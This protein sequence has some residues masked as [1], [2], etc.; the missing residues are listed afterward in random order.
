MPAISTLVLLGGA[1]ALAA[2]QMAQ[3]AGAKIPFF[4]VCIDYG[5]PDAGKE[6][7][8]IYGERLDS[9]LQREFMLIL[10][11]KTSV[12]VVPSKLLMSEGSTSVAG[13]SLPF[14]TVGQLAS[15]G[16]LAGKRVLVTT[17]FG[18]VVGDIVGNIATGKPAERIAMPTGSPIMFGLL[19]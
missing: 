17:E 1:A 14:V 9:R 19:A 11:G 8:L 2:S 18:I 10:A 6:V 7:P 5:T 13:G 3:S 4:L 12:P 16:N 15:L